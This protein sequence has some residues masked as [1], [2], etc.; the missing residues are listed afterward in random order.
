VKPEQQAIAFR[1]HKR[2]K[3]EENVE[4]KEEGEGKRGT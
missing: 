1:A 2:V 3:E 4:E